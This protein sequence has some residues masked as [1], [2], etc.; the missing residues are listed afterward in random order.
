[1]STTESTLYGGTLPPTLAP[2]QSITRDT[3]VTPPTTPA[4][5]EA[6]SLA[7]T[8]ADLTWLLVLAAVLIA[9]GAIVRA[10]ARKAAA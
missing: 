8:G 9:C 6:G 4:R 10:A 2:P 7:F 1:M 3:V 5:E